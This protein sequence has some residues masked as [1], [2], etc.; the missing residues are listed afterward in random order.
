MK[1]W[2]KRI[3]REETVEESVTHANDL[4]KGKPWNLK[5]NKKREYMKKKEKTENKK[6]ECK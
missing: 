6:D 3:N 4:R 5:D 1:T 2:E